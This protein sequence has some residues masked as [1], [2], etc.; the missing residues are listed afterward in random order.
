M[1]R[2]LSAI[3]FLL[4]FSTA[5]HGQ[6]EAI[7]QTTGK[8]I[9]VYQDG[10]WIYVDS[11]PHY[12]IKPT[13]IKDLELP[14]INSKETIIYHSGFALKF[15]KTHRQSSWVAYELTKAETSKLYDRTDKFL[16]DPK[17]KSG[18]AKDVDYYKSGYDRGHLAPAG[19]MA[20]SMASI[21]ESFYYSNVS[22]Q[23]PSFNRGVWKR[24]EDQVRSWAEENEKVFVVTGPVLN[25]Q[26]S[27][28]GPNK[29]TVPSYFYKVVLDYS[30]PSVKGIGFILQNVASQDNLQSFV[31]SIDSVESLTGIDFFH[32]LPD[33]H[34]N[35]IES[36]ICLKCWSWKTTKKQSEENDNRLTAS[37]QCKGITKAGAQ[38]RNR[39]FQESGFCHVHSNQADG[40]NVGGEN[41]KQKPFKQSTSVQCSGTTKAGSRCKRMTLD[42]SGRCYQH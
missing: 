42:P 31:V 16:P 3:C 20:W 6:E 4:A 30:L 1:R 21:T 15:N 33:D 36:T 37:V 9:V 2:I 17:I 25:N 7:V 18:M 27:H 13:D 29:I 11:I 39:T 10:T 5:S 35:E 24:L 38:C 22:P 19:D 34:E 12:Y 26:Q 23:V 32:L 28:I 14:K 40:Q 41:E 8:K